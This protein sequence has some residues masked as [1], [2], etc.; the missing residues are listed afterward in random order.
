MT[1]RFIAKR[2][3]VAIIALLFADPA[4][5]S[6][7]FVRDWSVNGPGGR[8]GLEEWGHSLS[9]RTRTWVHVGPLG[10]FVVPMSAPLTVAA[11]AVIVVIAGAPFLI[12]FGTGSR[13]GRRSSDRTHE[14]DDT[15]ST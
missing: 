10:T 3:S 7:Q 5:A 14:H 1:L 8:Y 9:R 13:R 4:F 11:A 6:P 15:P 2:I 12:P